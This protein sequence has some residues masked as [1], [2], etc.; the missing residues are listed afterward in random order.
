MQD[1]SSWYRVIYILASLN[2][3]SVIGMCT[4][5][6]QKMVKRLLINAKTGVGNRAEFMAS[7]TAP[8]LARFYL[9]SEYLSGVFQNLRQYLKNVLPLSEIG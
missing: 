8:K 7:G 3:G 2:I 5:Q 4:F 1:L 9:I 6:K